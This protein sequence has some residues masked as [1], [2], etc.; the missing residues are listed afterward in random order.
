MTNA[1][2]IAARIAR[3]G[4]GG[5][6]HMTLLNGRA[7]DA[8]KYLEDLCKEVIRGL[9]E[10]MIMDGRLTNTGIGCVFAMGEGESELMFYDDVTGE[11]LDFEMAA[12]ARE[13]EV[14]QFRKHGVYHK[15]PMQECYEK[16]GKAPI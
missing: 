1:E 6:K 14:D 16:T 5:H 10:Q 15:V 3:Q 8:E 12:R 11:V 4:Q 13:D 2:C 7:K 9:R